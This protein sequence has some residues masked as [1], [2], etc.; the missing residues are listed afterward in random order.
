MAIGYFGFVKVYQI[1]PELD[2]CTE[3]TSFDGGTVL[4]KSS[5]SLS[6]DGLTL[7]FALP[8]VHVYRFNGVDWDEFTPD[9]KPEG[10]NVIVSRNGSR[11]A[12]GMCR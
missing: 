10:T 9:Q 5:V 3:M 2:T 8:E 7:A 1:D 11:V 4:S 12:I 6:A